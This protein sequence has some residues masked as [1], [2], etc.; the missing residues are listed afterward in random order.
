M[1]EA[2]DLLEE[3]TAAGG[4][5]ALAQIGF[6]SDESITNQLNDYALDY[7]KDRSA[8]MVGKKYVDGELVDNPNAEWVIPETTREMLRADVS[9]AIESGASND[10]LADQLAENYAFSDER[11]Q[12]IARTETAKADVAGNLNAYKESGQVESKRWLTAPDCCDLCQDLD[13][14]TVGLDED[15]PDDGGDG[16]PLHPN[17]RCDVLPVLSDDTE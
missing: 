17:C 16:P 2:Q 1:D 7:A 8:E 9:T 6:N 10:D 15:F 5:D 3:I 14:V 12:T 11:A 13:D 4:A